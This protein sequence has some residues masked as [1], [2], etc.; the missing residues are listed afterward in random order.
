MV[1][2]IRIV[3]DLVVGRITNL[4]WCGSWKKTRDDGCEIW[5][6]PKKMVVKARG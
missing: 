5:S 6:G 1:G 2:W 3:E 4:N